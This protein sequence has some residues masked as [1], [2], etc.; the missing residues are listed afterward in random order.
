MSSR[1]PEQSGIF[2]VRTGFLRITQQF[3]RP[4][5]LKR[6]S[7]RVSVILLLV[8]AGIAGL[9][10]AHRRSL[11]GRWA[12]SMRG[13]DALPFEIKKARQALVD[14]D[15]DEKTLASTLDARMKYAESLHSE[16]FFLVLDTA[17]KRF[18]FQYGNRV[19]RDG[20]AEPGP[21]RTIELGANRWTFAALSGAYS[22]R[23]KLEDADWKAPAWA[24]AMSGTA[25]PNPLPTIPSGLGR[26]VLVLSG[27]EAVVHSPP[28]EGSPL[29]GPKPGS[30]E[31]PEA[32]LAAI[33]KRIG[34]R[35]RV[36]V[37][38]PEKPEVPSA[39]ELA[40]LGEA[41]SAPSSRIS[42][43]KGKASAAARKPAASHR[44]GPR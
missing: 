39:T 24:Y 9:A 4:K 21:E 14:L 44:T 40:M 34:P 13:T 27:G 16:D 23:E 20:A 35:T 10:F 28:P 31:V 42:R 12:T 3:R 1:I 41:R 7:W 38:G 43:E 25:P 36:Y 8:A 30:I 15:A 6:P 2:T 19:V 33:W 29:K 22:I 17:R 5:K 18:R 32:D 11:D 26:Y 37:F